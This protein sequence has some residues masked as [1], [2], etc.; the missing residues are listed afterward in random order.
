MSSKSNKRESLLTQFENM[1]KQ[2]NEESEGK[3]EPQPN[4][5]DVT[6]GA[7]IK[8]PSLFSNV[9]NKRDK[10][11]SMPIFAGSATHNGVFT[12]NNGKDMNFVMGL[13]ENLL[14][15]CRRLQAEN[16]EKNGTINQLQDEYQNLED[17]HEKLDSSHQVTSKELT[18]LK[19]TN[20]ELEVKLQQFSVEFKELKDKL[21]RNKKELKVEQENSKTTMAELEVSRLQ[22]TG[23]EKEL[24]EREKEYSAELT[25]LRK[26]VS[27]LNDENDS[28]YG[29]IKTL[30]KKILQNESLRT[31][32]SES[33]QLVDNLKRQLGELE[34]KLE[35]SSDN[36][37]LK[38][39]LSKSESTV[40]KLKLQLTD[41]KTKNKNHDDLQL[42][43]LHSRGL[44]SKLKQQ[45]A[46]FE[47]T[48]NSN[49]DE[50]KALKSNMEL[51]NQ[52][53]ENLRLQVS[54][55]QKQ[56][57]ERDNDKNNSLQSE[58]SQSKQLVE[59]LRQQLATFETKK[60]T[61]NRNT[62][63][64]VR[65]RSKGRSVDVKELSDQE[66][67]VS[68]TMD[69]LAALENLE[70]ELAADEESNIP[71][72]KVEKY[73]KLHKMRLI[74]ESE[75]SKAQLH[76]R[77]DSNEQLVNT[78]GDTNLLALPN[79]NS[80][81]KKY[82]EGATSIDAMIER[83]E[84]SGYKVL[85]FP[86]FNEKQE[87]LHELENPSK[88][89]LKS[90]ASHLGKILVSQDSY[91]KA[92]NPP[93]S[94]LKET[95]EKAGYT[96]IGND[97]YKKMVASIETPELNYLDTKLAAKGKMAVT[98]EDFKNYTSPGVQ[99]VE[100]L[101]KSI[102]YVAIA[103]EKYN[104]MQRKI[105]EPSIETILSTLDKQDFQAILSQ[106]GK[107]HH[108][109]LLN[110]KDHDHLVSAFANPSKQYLI[111]KCPSQQ[112]QPVPIDEYHRMLQTLQNP[113]LEFMNDK[114]T[115]MNKKLIPLKT[116]EKLRRTS[117][118]PS[119]DFLRQHAKKNHF[120]MLSE[121]D[122]HTMQRTL[123]EPNI[124]YLQAKA[125]NHKLVDLETHDKLTRTFNTP[126]LE[127]LTEK[128]SG[129][130]YDVVNTKEHK[131][132]LRKVMRPTE[133]EISQSARNLGAVVVQVEEYEG[134]KEITSAP[135]KDF[136]LEK[137]NKLN[138]V[139]LENGEYEKLKK[140]STDKESLFSSVKGLGFFPVPIPELNTLR[141]S[142]LEKSNVSDIEKRLKTLGYVAVSIKQY[143]ELNKSHVDRAT[144]E[145]TLALCSKYS[146]K[147]ISIEE[148]QKLKNDSKPTVYSEDELIE[149]LKSHGYAVMPVNE[150][151]AMT[152]MIK[153]PT[154]E[155]LEESA[156]QH[157]KV[158]INRDLHEQHINILDSATI[159]FLSEKASTL[160]YKVIAEKEYES[161]RAQIDSPSTDSLKKMA[162]LYNLTLIPHAKYN[163]LMND[164][165]NPSLSTLQTKATAM[166]KRVVDNA[167]YGELQRKT[168]SPTKEELQTLAV[169]LNMVL[170]VKD[171]Y[172]NLLKQIDH[173]SLRKLAQFQYV[174]I[175]ASDHHA[176][177]KSVEDPSEHFLSEK[178]ASRGMLL[179]SKTD[180]EGH[181]DALENPSLEYLGESAKKY[182]K[183]LVSSSEIK[184]PDQAALIE[185]IAKGD[186]VTI[187]RKELDN[188]KN[189][190]E[191]PSTD[192]MI[193]KLEDSNYVVL[194]EGKFD[195]MKRQ[196]ESPHLDRV[197]KHA[198]EHGH[199]LVRSKDLAEQSSHDVEDLGPLT[200]E[201]SFLLLNAEEYDALLNS[202]IDTLGQRDLLRMCDKLGL[203]P[204]PRAKYEELNSTP[205]VTRLQEYA[206][207]LGMVVI[208]QDDFDE[209]ISELEKPLEQSVHSFAEENN[210]LLI[211]KDSYENLLFRLN[212]PTKDELEKHSERLGLVLVPSK[213]YETLVEQF[214]YKSSSS[215]PLQEGL[216]EAKENTNSGALHGSSASSGMLRSS[217]EEHGKS[218]DNISTPAFS[219]TD[220]YRAAESL[221]LT[222]LAADEYESLL[223]RNS[224]AEAVTL[225]DIQE[226]AARHNMKL[227]PST[228]QGYG[229]STSQL[230]MA[231]D[232]TSTDSI[233]FKHNST[234]TIG[235]DFTNYFDTMEGRPAEITEAQKVE[236]SKEVYSG[237]NRFVSQS[238]EQ[239]K[240]MS[241]A[242]QE[243]TLKT[244]GTPSTSR[245]EPLS[246]ETLKEKAAEVG[247]VLVPASEYELTSKKNESTE[248][249]D[250]EDWY[251]AANFE[252]GSNNEAA[253]LEKKAKQL[254][255][256]LAP[257]SESQEDLNNRGKTVSPEVVSGQAARLGL[258]VLERETFQALDLK[259][260]DS[261]ERLEQLAEKF[262]CHVL[263]NEEYSLLDKRLKE[264]ELNIDNIQAKAGE[265]G[266]HVLNEEQYEELKDAA[267]AGRKELT[268]EEFK[269][270][271]TEFDLVPLSAAAYGELMSKSAAEPRELNEEDIK[272][273]A[274]ALGLTTMP[275]DA[276]K[277]LL[278]K[279]IPQEATKEYLEERASKLGMTV[280]SNR[281]YEELSTRRK[282][283]A[284]TKDM[285]MSRAR[286][287]G[288]TVLPNSTYKELT[289]AN[290]FENSKESITGDAQRLGLK[291]MGK[292]EYDTLLSH[293]KRQRITMKDVVEK[294]GEFGM[295]LVPK[296]QM[297][298]KS[299]LTKDDIVHASG[300]FGLV[301][302]GKKE[303]ARLQRLSKP[304]SLKERAQAAN[305][306]CLPKSAIIASPDRTNVDD[307]VVIP[308]AYYKKLLSREASMISARKQQVEMSK[309]SAR[310]PQRI[311]RQESIRSTQ[312][313]RPVQKVREQRSINSLMG[314]TRSATGV[315]SGVGPGPVVA[316]NAS[317]SSSREVPIPRASS[318]GALS[319][320]TLESLNE[321][322]IIPALTQTVIGEYLYKYYQVFGVGGESRHERYF[323]VHPYSMT[324]YWSPTNPVVE[325]PTNHSTKC[326]PIV[327]VDSVIDKNPTQGL[328]HKCLVITTDTRVIKI[329]CPS[330]QRHN[331]WYNSLRYLLQRSMEGINLE[332][333]AENPSDTMYSGKIFALS[334]QPSKKLPMSTSSSF[335]RGKH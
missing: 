278:S 103:Q 333:I 41:L 264:A 185:E 129:K 234:S 91:N 6:Q 307:L 118:N 322:S 4:A 13:S 18:A 8:K 62:R 178:A 182:S 291:V 137:A 113:T 314:S 76:K 79:D 77:T 198:K 211:E 271:A 71:I 172:D 270:K 160:G 209:M 300:K 27:E 96:I 97:E 283:P 215:L 284:I 152:G 308:T 335:L 37:I 332:D 217:N 204:V 282:R 281:A 304:E 319:L 235:S 155:F 260:K 175:P 149:M 199:V 44:I 232:S 116:F 287:Y 224:P 35:N 227:L 197:A 98:A 318:M 86:E 143:N 52:E 230:R 225:K 266:Y 293:T 248:V 228:E 132:L 302:L 268:P 324:L 310:P 131:E 110:K 95:L 146:F 57:H 206:T 26:N 171:E 133:D 186:L 89:Y 140:A 326:A 74:S 329:A 34:T 124:E 297:N 64:K 14:V 195:E 93:A 269:N 299:E 75:Y 109:V 323:W 265:L 78:V 190:A 156:A 161:L 53:A 245:A 295:A 22:R 214:K 285:I 7:D 188:L 112:I 316:S 176:L 242:S 237:N 255:F 136:I 154:A 179:L 128:A 286:D 54:E 105:T 257:S 328:Y 261:K 117:E 145:D 65:K 150:H 15:E 311:A 196:I 122:H 144:K 219:K 153:S 296:E 84:S 321:P 115:S 72:E 236:K 313:G 141:G 246:I 220:V 147:P 82:I 173:P 114:A 29:R 40:N 111:E 174:A 294:S 201:G 119:V 42:E 267:T 38:A 334:K 243:S 30:D 231:I 85:S 309:P 238:P 19:D 273:R 28:L 69:K 167:E 203:I 142:T 223:S 212:N 3:S 187:A 298:K 121:D 123:N 305:M 208:S 330:R 189:S 169:T 290:S 226:F 289:S 191:N 32:L 94:Q 59:E 16:E 50:N 83:V 256:V 1:H 288:L 107:K 164:V 317:N 9:L 58:L 148:Y 325:N 66:S 55:L 33:A 244:S 177:K 253:I 126:S 39:Q 216:T 241:L 275:N 2:L 279:Q 151:E 92:V 11:N 194:D 120:I 63:M 24:A 274:S 259:A 68:E 193:P 125:K 170:V 36:G 222:V 67:D 280:L 127:F 303:F 168:S 87:K 276:Y 135:S 159:E 254:G 233:E 277:N 20:W 108:L 180:H 247:Y 5:G 162:G 262:G 184:T 252:S 240:S 31:Q 81:Q 102:G 80:S 312:S 21:N 166:R 210:L 61:S 130:G 213:Q 229:N 207:E 106:F 46:T 101:T 181:M 48:T 272:K 250:T 258:V 60:G 165:N 56:L 88:K 183:V 100:D 73:A 90:K 12:A 17:K 23:L 306:I 49:V 331:V 25:E 192:V 205:D 200:K 301:T 51:I 320:N 218:S 263:Q 249:E 47:A 134:L 104:E 292:E 251:D 202:N 158:L 239:I 10:N 163:K 157:G 138:M 221:D 139:V 327:K 43:L 45:V 70:D 99:F 315:G